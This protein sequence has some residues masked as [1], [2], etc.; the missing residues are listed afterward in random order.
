MSAELRAALRAKYE[1]PDAAMA[2]LG[3]DANLLRQDYGGFV[4]DRRARDQELPAHI[5]KQVDALSDDSAMRIARHISKRFAR[6]QELDDG[7]EGGN[8]INLGERICELLE[9][10]NVDPEIVDSV[11]ELLAAGDG[12]GTLHI[13]HRGSQDPSGGYD[14][15]GRSPSFGQDQPPPTP[16]TP[17]TD[18]PVQQS[19]RIEMVLNLKTAK[20][21]GL[22]V[23]QTLL[24][25]ADEVIE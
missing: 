4:M 24:V 2:A 22:N 13:T 8:D 10:A 1:T 20:A 3:L 17:R 11:K 19:T 14:P 25:A 15:T 21:L 23:P 12:D 5:A 18:L 9:S 6:D 7:Q 16:G